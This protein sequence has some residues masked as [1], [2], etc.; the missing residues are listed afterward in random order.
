MDL[1]KYMMQGKRTEQEN[2][3]IM[4]KLF[5]GIDYMHSIGIVHRDIKL[6]NI[7]IH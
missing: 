4:R 2:L 3:R 5:E 1:C 7:M 6:E